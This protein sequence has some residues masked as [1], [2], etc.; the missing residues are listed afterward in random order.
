MLRNSIALFAV[1]GLVATLFAGGFWQKKPYDQW[2]RQEVVRML[3]RSPW[4]KVLVI[5]VKSPAPGNPSADLEAKFKLKDM[6]ID[7]QLEL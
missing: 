7:G 2:S 6:L 4:S 1:G 3:T 5:A